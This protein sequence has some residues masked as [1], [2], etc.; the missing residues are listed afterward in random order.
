[1]TRAS[2]SVA[3]TAPVDK[4][5]GKGEGATAK[6]FTIDDHEVDI[7]DGETIFRAA[8]RLGIELPHLCYSPKP[9]YRPDGNCR[10]CMVEIEGERVLAASCI[11][12]PAPGMKVKTQTD[13]AKTARKMVAELLVDRPAGAR[14][15]ARSGFRVLEGRDPHGAQAGPLPAPR[16]ACA[17]PQPRRHGGQ[18]RRLHPVQS[19]RP[20]LPRSAGQRRHRHGRPRPWREDRVRLRRSDG[21]LDLRRLRRMRAGLPDR[22]ADAG[23]DGRRQQ[24]LQRQARPHGRQRLPLLRRRLPAHL[25]DQGRQ[26]RRRHRQG[27]P[28]EPE[29]AVRQRPLRLRLRAQSAAAAQADDPQGRRAESAARVHRPVQSVD[30]FPRGDLGRGA[31]SRGLGLEEDPRPRRA[32]RRSP[33]SARP[34]ART[35]RLICSRS[36]C[37]PASAPTMSITAR[38]CATPPRW[39]RCWKASAR[40]R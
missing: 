24:R 23:D 17:G 22:R 9:G 11:R 13:R 32:A 31:R 28:G 30:A 37:A 12:T 18:S 20:R 3:H 8:R 33:A 16:D 25:P 39:R 36:W 40:R 34:R 27:R 1:M 4:V 2:R 21:R 5:A 29:P 35:K 19:V 14:R 15:R 10:V 38:G 26:D 7:R 6:T